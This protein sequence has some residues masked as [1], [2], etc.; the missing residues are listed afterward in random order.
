M[1]E[2]NKKMAEKNSSDIENLDERSNNIIKEAR[3]EAE[4][5]LQ[6]SIQKAQQEQ[7]IQINEQRSLL[8]SEHEMFLASLETE[9]LKYKKHLSDKI[10]NLDQNVKNKLSNLA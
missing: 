1:I 6:E 2:N 10:V 9:V 8:D 3:V 5:I 7:S 4:R